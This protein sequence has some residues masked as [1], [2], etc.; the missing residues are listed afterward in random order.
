MNQR[1]WGELCR[2]SVE[3]RFNFLTERISSNK[4][5]LKAFGFFSFRGADFGDEESAFELSF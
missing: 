2:S 3:I 1:E 4:I 5:T